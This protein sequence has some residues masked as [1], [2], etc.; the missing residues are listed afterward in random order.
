MVAYASSHGSTKL[1][2]DNFDDLTLG[3][4]VFIKFYS[5]TCGH[6]QVPEIHFART[7]SSYS[8]LPKTQLLKEEFERAIIL[9]RKQSICV[10]SVTVTWPL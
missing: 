5:P 3:K 9:T 6:C 8:Q 7:S 4:S 2:R 10:S 1:T